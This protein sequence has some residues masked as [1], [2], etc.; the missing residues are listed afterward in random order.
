M[1]IKVKTKT[2]KKNVA[3]NKQNAF[4]STMICFFTI[5]KGIE[6]KTDKTQTM[7]TTTDVRCFVILT[8]SGN[9]MAINRSQEIADSVSTLHVRQVTVKKTRKIRNYTYSFFGYIL[10]GKRSRSSHWK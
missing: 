5:R 10:L 3:A 2:E 8:W 9:I 7:V 4:T 1:K 6:T